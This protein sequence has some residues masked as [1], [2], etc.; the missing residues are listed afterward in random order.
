MFTFASVGS[1]AEERKFYVGGSISRAEIDG[2]IST[3]E[4]VTFFPFSPFPTQLGF[5]TAGLDGLE[6]DETARVWGAFAGYNFSRYFGV[7]V[8]YRD[9]G[10]YV[11]VDFLLDSSSF[12]ISELSISAKLR[13]PVSRSVSLTGRLGASRNF[14]DTS[15]QAAGALSFADGGFI[16]RATKP[17][18]TPSDETGY[19]WGVGAEWRVTEGIGI[20]VNF[21]R[22]ETGII[23]VD[24]I[25]VSVLLFF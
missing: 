21:V 19:L 12:Q 11:P 20:G 14:F 5:R 10:S 3:D 17:V 15:G 22:H 9:L 18:S 6:V 16:F 1:A 7:E 13:F 4:G 2:T 24:T 25:D 8:G 23:D